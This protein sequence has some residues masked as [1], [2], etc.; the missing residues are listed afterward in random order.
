MTLLNFL[1]NLKRSMKARKICLKDDTG[2]FVDHK[3]QK[4]RQKQKPLQKPL[5]KPKTEVEAKQLVSARAE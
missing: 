5:Q 3:K 4:P 1:S 2:R